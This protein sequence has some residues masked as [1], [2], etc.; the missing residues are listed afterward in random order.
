MREKPNIFEFFRASNYDKASCGVYRPT[1]V[2]A[3]KHPQGNDRLVDAYS[4]DLQE[5]IL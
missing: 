3:N 5:N 4:L 2:T 1:P